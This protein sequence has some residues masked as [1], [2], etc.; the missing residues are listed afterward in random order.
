MKF[1]EQNTQMR[2]TCFSEINKIKL[3]E[4]KTKRLENLTEIE[5][6]QI[7]EC[8]ISA[9]L[10]WLKSYTGGEETVE[11]AKEF[12]SM[13]VIKAVQDYDINKKTAFSSYLFMRARGHCNSEYQKVKRRYLNVQKWK[14]GKKLG[15]KK[16]VQFI[17]YQAEEHPLNFL[18]ALLQ[19]NEID[20]YETNFYFGLDK[21]IE[22]Q[23]TL[24]RLKTIKECLDRL[25]KTAPHL[26][27]TVKWIDRRSE[28]KKT[29]GIK[30]HENSKWLSTAL[31]NI[32]HYIT[33]GI[34]LN[35]GKKLGN[36]IVADKIKAA[37]G[38]RCWIDDWID[39]LET[40]LG[41]HK[42]KTEKMLDT[43]E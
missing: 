3:H 15:N 35:N 43:A 6:K 13:I 5:A 34:M 20:T 37:V 33:Q 42:K 40:E 11:L 14:N 29:F 36:K 23:K 2:L 25:D 8:A 18:G 10:Y 28:F 4:D 22:Q 9:A 39:H 31:R 7:Y 19:E 17:N 24:Y 1:K 32:R 38:S 30:T 12:A 27:A 21:P 41:A 16:D 26:S